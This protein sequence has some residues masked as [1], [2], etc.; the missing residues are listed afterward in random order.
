MDNEED[1]LSNP[2]AYS[3]TDRID[4][5]LRPHCDILEAL[6]TD[7]E[8]L[9]PD[10]PACRFVMKAQE[11]RSEAFIRAGVIP[12]TGDLDIIEQARIINWIYKN[13]PT[14]ADNM[15]RWISKATNAHAITLVLA[16]E[17]HEE[18]M[19]Q[20]N[21]PKDD[22]LEVQGSFSLDA[23]WRYQMQPREKY[24]VDVDR[25]C[26][27]A[28]EEAM[29]ECSIEAGKAGNQQ[30]GLDTGPH[31]DDWNPYINLPYHWNHGDFVSSETELE[32]RPIDLHHYSQ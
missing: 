26:I 11:E 7:D 10:I 19:Q 18:I 16:S 2:T 15:V 3:Y 28:L 22:S 8:A 27:S 25:E 12:H 13:V 32:V 29:F 4:R 24:A 20:G 1:V 5:I 31:K 17:H 14:A 30:W 9:H 6:L 21:F 23:A